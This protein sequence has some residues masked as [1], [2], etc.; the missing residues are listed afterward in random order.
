MEHL[1]RQ[2]FGSDSLLAI[3]T[4]QQFEPGSPEASGPRKLCVP[5]FVTSG[6]ENICT[7]FVTSKTAADKRNHILQLLRRSKREKNDSSGCYQIRMFRRQLF[8]KQPM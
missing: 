5:G 1:S 4:G 6:K 7:L 8:Y 3:G 2:A